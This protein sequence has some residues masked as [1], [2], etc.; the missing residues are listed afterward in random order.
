MEGEIVS[1]RKNDPDS[2]KPAFGF[3]KAD[4]GKTG[5]AL[6]NVFFSEKFLAPDTTVDDLVKGV[7]VRFDVINGEKGPMAVDVSKIEQSTEKNREKDE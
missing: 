4:P 6:K 3:I 5:E 7:R 2:A 1:L